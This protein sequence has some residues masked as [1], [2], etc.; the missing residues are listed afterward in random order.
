[1]QPAFAVYTSGM[2]SKVKV[3]VIGT[4][5]L[6]KEHARIYFELSRVGAVEFVGV[7]DVSREAAARIGENSA[8]AASS[9]SPKPRRNAMPRAWSRPRARHKK[10]H[11]PCS[12]QANTSLSK[13]P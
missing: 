11:A 7:F 8:C 2:V 10:S 3:A 9:R 1:M 4:G 6:G 12:K 13:S 5:S